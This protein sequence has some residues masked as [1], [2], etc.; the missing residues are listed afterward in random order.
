MGSAGRT[1]PLFTQ[2]ELGGVNA[3]TAGS[4]DAS[5]SFDANMPLSHVAYSIG[6][7]GMYLSPTPNERPNAIDIAETEPCPQGR[8]ILGGC[9]PIAGDKPLHSDDSSVGGSPGFG[10]FSED[11]MKRVGLF[12]IALV[13][14]AVALWKL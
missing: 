10:F 13:I 14:L 3:L 11:T 1:G 4:F 2:L 5:T 8:N 12:F 6:V 9:G 7:L